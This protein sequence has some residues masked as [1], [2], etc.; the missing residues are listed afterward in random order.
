MKKM[1]TAACFALGLI[2]APAL[3]QGVAQAANEPAKEAAINQLLD[4]MEF[5]KTI[6]LMMQGMKAQMPQQMMA[7]VRTA[8]DQS[9]VSPEKKQ[10]ALALAQKEMPAFMESM[11]EKVLGKE[12]REEVT[13]QTIRIYSRHFTTEEIEQLAAFYRSPVGKK[14]IAKMPVIMQESMQ[15]TMQYMMKRMPVLAEEAGKRFAPAAQ[16]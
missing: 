1:I 6:A 14:M 10:E 8:I 5:E 15:D 12:F 3:A 2:A 11:M 9:G 7:G 13:L 16:K 4:A